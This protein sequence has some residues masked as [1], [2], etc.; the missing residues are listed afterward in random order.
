[1]PSSTLSPFSVGSYYAVNSIVI[2]DFTDEETKV[3]SILVICQRS[4]NK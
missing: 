4:Q 1:M 2:L 3:Q